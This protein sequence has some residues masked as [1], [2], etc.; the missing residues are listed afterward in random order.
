MNPYYAIGDTSGIFSPALILYKDLIRHNIGE[1]IRIAGNPGRLRPHVKTHKTREIVRLQMDAGVVT[2][3]AS[4]PFAC[5][6][7]V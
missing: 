5:S 2:S 6:P 1:M 7:S 3:S 4:P